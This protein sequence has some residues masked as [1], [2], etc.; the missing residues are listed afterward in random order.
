M[1]LAAKLL[2]SKVQQ[3]ANV[4]AFADC[5][6]LLTLLFAAAA[7]AVAFAKRPMPPPGDA[8]PGGGH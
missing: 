4:M 3:Q 6:F 7:I 8:A 2:G 1:M 5:F